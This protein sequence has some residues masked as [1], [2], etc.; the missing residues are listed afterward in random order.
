MDNGLNLQC[1]AWTLWAIW[2]GNR[3][4]WECVQHPMKDLLPQQGTPDTISLDAMDQSLSDL[5]RDQRLE[6]HL[7]W[8]WRWF[9]SAQLG[10]CWLTWC[11]YVEKKGSLLTSHFAQ[12][13][14]SAV[15]L[16]V[17]FVKIL[18][19]LGQHLSTW[20]WTECPADFWK[21]MHMWIH[22]DVACNISAFGAIFFA[23]VTSYRS[24]CSE[25]MVPRTV[26]SCSLRDNKLMGWKYWPG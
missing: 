7:I 25:V 14:F 1:S 3:R 21:D 10:G 12:G 20:L 22:V 6:T 8:L 13:I 17:C 4:C 5:V 2:H 15:S 9:Q 26:F 18:P 11:L 24:S 23:L 16:L 19:G